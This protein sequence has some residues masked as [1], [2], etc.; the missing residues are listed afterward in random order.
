MANNSRQALPCFVNNIRIK[1][2]GLWLKPKPLCTYGF[3][4][5]T[6]A[7]I[8]FTQGTIL[9]TN[10]PHK[11]QLLSAIK[12]LQ[13]RQDELKQDYSQAINALLCTVKD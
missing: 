12:E 9:I 11:Q 10:Q 4:S 13:Y 7:T 6:Q 8:L 5:N 3:N 1:N 2:N